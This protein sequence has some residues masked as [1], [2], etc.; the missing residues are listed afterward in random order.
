MKQTER[1]GFGGKKPYLTSPRGGTQYVK[2]TII[3]Y[4]VKLE[5]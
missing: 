1:R 3:K 4:K 5:K 2:N